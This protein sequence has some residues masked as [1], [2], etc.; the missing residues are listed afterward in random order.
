MRL[1]RG[2]NA[3]LPG[4][5]NMSSSDEAITIKAVDDSGLPVSCAWQLIYDKGFEYSERI[6]SLSSTPHTFTATG[7]S[8]QYTPPSNALQSWQGRQH[9]II[10]AMPSDGSATRSLQITI[11]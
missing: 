6:G 1:T 11:G 9:A 2:N 7:T 5:L 8:V 3:Q 4:T 10:I